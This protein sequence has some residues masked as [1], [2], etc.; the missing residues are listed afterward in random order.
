MCIDSQSIAG[1]QGLLISS[2][3]ANGIL[4]RKGGVDDIVMGV[5]FWP[6]EAQRG[7]RKREL[8]DRLI[9][10]GEESFVNAQEEDRWTPLHLASSE[11]H[12]STAKSLIDRGANVGTLTLSDN[13]HR[14]A[15]SSSGQSWS[16]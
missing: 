9:H 2:T 10:I 13:R 6:K 8:R 3:C 4:L 5:H 1:P 16:F 11:G 15:L 12:L 14:A 7:E